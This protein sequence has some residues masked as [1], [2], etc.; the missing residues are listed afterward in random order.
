LTQYLLYLCKLFSK[1][2][3]SL[4][5]ICVM[6]KSLSFQVSPQLKMIAVMAL[7]QRQ[8]SMTF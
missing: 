1:S 5:L 7:F 4:N 3:E 8:A 6:S 2:G